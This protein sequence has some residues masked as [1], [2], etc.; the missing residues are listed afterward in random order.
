MKF[1]LIEILHNCQNYKTKQEQKIPRIFN[2]SE[3]SYALT[4]D[5]NY[6]V[7]DTNSCSNFVI[8]VCEKTI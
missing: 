8:L 7:S 5:M 2:I 4:Q 1:R 3:Y 6:F